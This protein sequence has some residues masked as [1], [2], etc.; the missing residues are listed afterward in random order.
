MRFISRARANDMIPWELRDKAGI[1][2]R[3][4]RGTE[5]TE[6]IEGV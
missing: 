1:Q 4:H 5:C 3:A 2:H 6:K